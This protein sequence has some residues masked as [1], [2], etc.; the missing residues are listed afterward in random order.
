M[1]ERVGILRSRNSLRRAL[2][3]FEQIGR[4]RLR[5]SPRNFLTVA[6]LIAR[7]ALWRE[8]SRGG[9]YRVDFPARDDERW[10]VHSVIQ[11]DAGINSSRTV[12]FTKAADNG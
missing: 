10:R 1:W 9:H 12:E 6:S 5:P 7:S 11:K 2:S 8:E 4:A 3:E